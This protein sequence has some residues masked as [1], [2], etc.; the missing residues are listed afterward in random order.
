MEIIQP[1]LVVHADW[2]AGAAKRWMAIAALEP[3]GRYL[4]CAPQPVGEPETL[5]QRLRGR[6]GPA[7]SLLVGFDFPIGLPL[8]YARLCG[9]DDF[10][11]VLPGLGEGVWGNFYR[12]AAQVDEICLQRPFYPARPGNARQRHLLSALGVQSMNDLR[13][14]CERS[15][16]GRRPAAPLFWTLGGQQVGKAAISGWTQVLAPALR[17]AGNSTAIVIW[18]FSGPLSQIMQP[19]ATVVAETYPAEYYRHLGV[20]FSPQTGGK[21]SQAAR[22][23][24]AGALVDWAARAKVSLAPELC[25][26]LQDGFGPAPA[27][28]DAF[29][30]VVG[31]FG[32]LNLILGLRPLEEPASQHLRKIEGWILGQSCL[33][34]QLE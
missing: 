22:Q 14:E 12:V 24:G 30:A 25:T 7:G 33:F 18:P 34:S 32:M 16:P 13:R 31:L 21:R 26:A 11:V 8:R 4:A 27:G 19:G 28:E 5:L 9:V 10:L 23:A 6:T 20:K 2:S 3:G 29:D 15:H 17:M 1:S